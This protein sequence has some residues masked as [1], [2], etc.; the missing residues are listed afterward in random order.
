MTIAKPGRLLALTIVVLASLLTGSHETTGTRRR[1]DEPLGLLDALLRTPVEWST[2][3]NNLKVVRPPEALATVD[4]IDMVDVAALWSAVER[5]PDEYQRR[6]ML[7]KIVASGTI[8]E[9]RMASAVELFAARVAKT[10]GL[11][12]WSGIARFKLGDAPVPGEVSLGMYLCEAAAENERLAA[13]LF[14][15]ERQLR[16]SDPR[17]AAILARILYTWPVPAAGRA[18]LDCVERG[19]STVEIV[20]AV[21]ERGE[22]LRAAEAPRL[23]ALVEA[24]GFAGGVAAALLGDDA[25]TRRVLTGEDTTAA[26]ALLACARL[27]R[28]PL[29]IDLVGARLGPYGDAAYAARRYL[30]IEDGPEARRLLSAHAVERAHIVGGR[31]EPFG[32]DSIE[33]ALVEIEARLRDEVLADGGPREILALLP[34]IVVRVW[35]DR[36][37]VTRSTVELLTGPR[38]VTTRTLGPEELADL[39]R[40]VRDRHV[41]DLPVYE[42]WTHDHWISPREFEFLRLSRDGGARVH[43]RIVPFGQPGADGGDAAVYEELRARF[44][45]L[46][47][48]GMENGER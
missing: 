48:K 15:R 24:G 35:P 4:V 36:A 30:E 42:E 39:E 28:A 1:A 9:E 8:T 41:V 37:E 18:L 14:D 19:D 10:G 17:V 33:A 40:F 16:R 44:T 3:R 27:A 43:F 29:P 32:D 12:D 45:A 47:T 2:W 38:V 11:R 13:M 5:E 22:L 6:P 34:D 25:T 21:V 23:R 46:I 26:C 7:A 31:V 20:V